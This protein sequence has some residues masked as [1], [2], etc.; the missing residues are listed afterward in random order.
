MLRFR[1][2]SRRR[3]TMLTSVVATVAVVVAAVG[4]TVQPARALWPHDPATNLPL[5]ATADLAS[6]PAAI[7]DGAGG[8]ITAW[9][10]ERAGNADIYAQ[11]VSADGVP[12]WTAGGVPICTAPGEQTQVVLCTDTAGGAVIAWTDRRGTSADIYAQRINSNAIVQWIANGVVVVSISGND[13][14]SP[15]IAASVS[16]SGGAYVFWQD[17]AATIYNIYG[18]HLTSFGTRLWASGGVLVSG[19]SGEQTDPRCIESGNH[20]IVAWSSTQAGNKDVY[21]EKMLSSG[22]PSWGTGSGIVVCNATGEQGDARLVDDGNQGAVICWEDLRTGAA[23]IYAQRIYFSGA[24]LWASNGLALC[25]EAAYQVNPAIAR[26]GTGGAIVAWSDARPTTGGTDIFAQRVNAAGVLQW[27]AN[28]VNVSNQP[29]S[30]EQ[31]VRLIDDGVGGAIAGWEDSR[32]SG[33]LDLFAQRLAS[34]GTARW[35]SGGVP[36]GTAPGVNNVRFAL[37]SDGENGV[38]AVFHDSRTTG[39]F[40]ELWLQAVDRFGTLGAAPQLTDVADTPNDQG[41]K[42]RLSWDA[43][44]LDVDP[45]FETIA[46]Y[47]VLRES[48]TAAAKAAVARGARVLSSPGDPIE[49]GRRNLLLD[50]A[51]A[52]PGAWEFL[53]ATPAFRADSYS[54]VAATTS[55]SVAGSNPLTRFVV[56]ARNATG[57]QWWFSN[58]LAGYSVD[59]LPPAA[60]VPFTGDYGSSQVQLAWGPNGEAD[61]ASYRL[62]R[63]TSPG[64]EIGPAALVVEQPTR[65]YLDAFTTAPYYK[66]VAVDSHGNVSPAT[67]LIPPGGTTAVA[68]T[69]LPSQLMLAP[70]S[71]NPSAGMSTLRWSLPTPQ[72]VTLGIFDAAGRRVRLLVDNTLP[73]GEHSLDWD[74]RDASGRSVAH[75]LYFARLETR[76]GV[77][78]VQVLRMR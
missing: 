3:W 41:G 36:V 11:R 76:Q 5:G 30:V 59:D 67:L 57:T 55:D 74:G 69:M 2:T 26:D 44:A 31:T 10:D 68:G 60:P 1:R 70:A 37:A 51:G 27:T 15:T 20:V 63:G 40:T 7:P 35:N 53:A 50:A 22:S 33:Q 28:G 73:A 9:V 45:L 25:T 56:Q 12:L 52:P 18:Q 65:G 13:E 61:F 78:A 34:T 32:R 24:A 49:A 39:G 54:Y 42:V 66:L 21:A 64:F 47:W 6:E 29:A 43:S 17:G 38:I 58:P 77:R 14:Q 62:Y 48:P 71:P 16:E 19:A 72:R 46:E 23:D 8:C 4:L 75:G